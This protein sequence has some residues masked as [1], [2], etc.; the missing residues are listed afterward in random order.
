MRTPGNS[1]R[2]YGRPPTWSSCACVI[3]NALT[4]ALRSLRYVMSGTTR[5]IPN[6]S[7]SGNISPQ[8][9]T[10]MSSP[11][12]NTYMFLPISPTPPRGMIRRI[13]CGP[14][15]RT[16]V[17]FLRSEDREV[18]GG[19]S[20]LRSGVGGDGEDLQGVG[21]DRGG[22]LRRRATRPRLEERPRRAADVGVALP[23]DRRRA[24]RGSRVIHREHRRGPGTRGRIHRADRAVDLGDPRAGPERRHRVAAQ[25]HDES[26]IEDFQLAPQVRRARGDLVRL[27]IAVVRRPALHDVR[28][29]DVVARPLD[30]AEELVQEPAGPADE[31]PAL[32]ILVEPGALADEDDL[33]V[34]AP[35]ARD[36]I[37]PRRAEPAPVAHP[38][39]RSDR[40][41]GRPSFFGRHAP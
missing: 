6:I 22:S 13:G 14:G 15:I 32:A 1:G 34:R 25:G 35:L 31:R 33:G 7:S 16:E 40:L 28:D 24:E 5:S 38:D 30:G 3:R 39:L 12:S 36:G 18:G 29:E 10:T 20:R 23:L 8:S 17:S 41:Q 37:R 2:T 21:L 26:R 4:L 9:I 11:Y 19:R 27:G